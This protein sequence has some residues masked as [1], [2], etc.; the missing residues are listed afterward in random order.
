V[1]ILADGSIH[2]IICSQVR[3]VVPAKELSHMLDALSPFDERMVEGT[4]ARL[5]KDD[6]SYV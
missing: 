6:G 3:G 5:N 1:Y 4:R 2:V